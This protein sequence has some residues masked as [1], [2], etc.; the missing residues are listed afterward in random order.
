MEPKL[1]LVKAITLLYRESQLD[2]SADGSAELVRQVVE[3][4]KIP[5]GMI[6]GDPT[7]DIII[8]LRQTAMWMASNPP[9]YDYDKN[10]LLQRIRVN[11]GYDTGLYEAFESGLYEIETDEEIKKVCLDYRD[12]LR[13]YLDRSNVKDIVKKASHQVMFNEESINW[14]N[15]VQDLIASLEQYASASVI[16]GSSAD[17]DSISFDDAGEMASMFQ[18]AAEEVSN[19][20]TIKFGWQGLNRMT[21][22]H[23]GGRRGEF[24]VVQ[25]LQHNFKTGCTLDMFK[26]AALYNKPHMRDPTKKPLLIHISLENNL[27]DNLIWLYVN[28]MENETGQPCDINNLGI[29]REDM[30]RYVMDRMSVNGYYI[31]MYRKNPSDFSFHD[32]FDMI[33]DLESKGFEVHMVVMDYLN[34]MTKKG[35]V[36]SGPSG[37]DIRDLFRRV[38]N[39]TT[40]RGILFITPHQLSSD[41]KALV[42]QGV[43]NFVQEVA[44]KGYYD[45][46]KRIDQEVDFELVIHIEKMGNKSYLT[47]QRGKHRKV[48]PTPQD[49]LYTVYKFEDV[50]TIPD[51]INAEDRSMKKVGGASSGGANMDAEWWA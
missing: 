30:A 23:N 26:Q 46:C 21:G 29:S 45:G 39:F 44:G 47:M 48:K 6:E 41:A 51:D 5:E 7:R 37:D 10:I 35:C 9:N 1:L 49:C 3:S 27:P 19:E 33:N 50:G 14:R 22:E 28:L 42:R 24:W 16:Q 18:R 20:G 31:K 38:R 8:G 2:A 11:T 40:P 15:Y 34:M 25:A 43:D 13:S 32:F 4:I 17:M 36:Q 12:V